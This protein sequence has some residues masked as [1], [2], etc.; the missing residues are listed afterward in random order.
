MFKS[1]GGGLQDVAVAEVVFRKA[2][3]AGRTVRLPIA[4][5]TKS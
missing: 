3:E 5:E 2:I 1:V 4:F